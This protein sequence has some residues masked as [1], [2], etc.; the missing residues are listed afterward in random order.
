MLNNAIDGIASLTFRARICKAQ[1]INRQFAGNVML[2]LDE[3][4]DFSQ[5]IDSF[6][7]AITIGKGSYAF[8]SDTDFM[9]ALIN[10][11]LYQTLRS[12]GTRYLLY[13]LEAHSKY[14]KGLQAFNDESLSIEHIMPRTLTPQWESYLTP[15]SLKNYNSSLHR[16]GNLTLT[17]YNGELSNKDFESKKTIYKDSKLY[18]TKHIADYDQWQITEID[19]RSQMLA[20][21]ALKIWQLPAKYQNTRASSKAL[22]TLDED[23][24][25][26]AYTKPSLLLIGNNEYSVNFWADILP[27]VC[28]H[29]DQENHDAFIEIAKPERIA[30]FGLEDDDNSYAENKK[31]THITGNVYIRPCMSSANTL[32]TVKKIAEEFDQ[33]AGTEF[34]ESIRF[35]LK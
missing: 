21:E 15:D 25:Q 35:S 23:M 24:H 33:I 14:S 28:L 2:R 17:N 32:E 9:E 7:Q 13:T 5:F 12:Q 26:F 34:A 18:Y 30:G 3:I 16:L 1:G 6:W 27:I 22:F 10:K 19:D 4:K 11:D 31:F 29:F 20:K 8:P